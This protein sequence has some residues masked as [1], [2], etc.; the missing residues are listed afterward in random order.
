MIAGLSHSKVL[1]TLSFELQ[2]TFSLADRTGPL[3]AKPPERVSAEDWKIECSETHGVQV[4]L[5]SSPQSPLSM[6][7]LQGTRQE[8]AQLNMLA[9]RGRE[10]RSGCANIPED[11]LEAR[12]GSRM[13]SSSAT[14]SA[15]EM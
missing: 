2:G 8:N 3:R 13:P 12:P 9:S 5:V 10:L 6:P 7:G 1:E 4:P 14:R 15:T 11:L